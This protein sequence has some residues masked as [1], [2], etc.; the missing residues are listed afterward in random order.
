MRN[1]K[2]SR[3]WIEPAY[4]ES[5]SDWQWESSHL[6]FHGELLVAASRYSSP[7]DDDPKIKSTN[8]LMPASPHSLLFTNTP[9][10]I[11]AQSMKDGQP[12]LLG[13]HADFTNHTVKVPLRTTEEDHIALDRPR[14]NAL[15]V[16]AQAMGAPKSVSFRPAVVAGGLNHG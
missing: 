13:L 14:R 5:G 2:M 1:S 4:I 7:A 6:P 15:G 16:T 9:S 11:R 10:R 8:R 12:H 3:T